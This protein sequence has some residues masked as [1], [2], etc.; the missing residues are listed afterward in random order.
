MVVK[1]FAIIVN[2]IKVRGNYI[3]TIHDLVQGDAIMTYWIKQ[4]R[5]PTNERG[6]IDWDVIK[7]AR[8]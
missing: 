3:N 2:K 4:G 1:I 5:F 8:A 7:H 6:T